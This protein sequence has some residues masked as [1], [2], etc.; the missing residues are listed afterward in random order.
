VVMEALTG[1]A[2]YPDQYETIAELAESHG[3]AEIRET[4]MELAAHMNDSRAFSLLARIFNNDPNMDVREEVLQTMDA[5]PEAQAVPF[6]LDVANNA[7]GYEEDLRAEAVDTLAEFSP[8]LVISDLNRLAWSDGSEDVR[9][10]AVK[11]L[12]ELIDS[13][14]NNL[15]LEIARNHPSNHT[16][17]EAM[18]ELEDRVL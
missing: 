11:A 4:A 7:G 15:L 17:R 18:D 6:L 16:R 14:V 10:S 5:V 12:A 13:S 3:D 2:H 9:E 8:S 1:L